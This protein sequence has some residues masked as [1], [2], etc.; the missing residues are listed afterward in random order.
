MCFEYVEFVKSSNWENTDS[1]FRVIA[2]ND[3]ARA[4]VDSW[5]SAQDDTN[6]S[7]ATLSLLH[8]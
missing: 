4:C 3:L 8:I 5:M 1:H 6:F 2:A 7:H